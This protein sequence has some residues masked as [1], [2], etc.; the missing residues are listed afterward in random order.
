MKT[1]RLADY[2]AEGLLQDLEDARFFAR[3]L[4]PEDRLDFEGV[5]AVSSDFLDTLLA[6]QKPDSLEGRILNQ[7]GAVDEALVAWVDRQQPGRTTVAP[8]AKT[9]TRSP[10]AARRKTAPP[11]EF[12]RPEPEG[13][14]YTPTRLINRL[15]QQL[16]SYIES[17]YP[18]SDPVLVRARRRLLEE[19]QDGH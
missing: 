12:N 7:A 10:V 11:V 19:A 13:E 9:G 8:T 15:R 18:L 3:K 16:R 5:L 4:G 6:G 2:A 17:A 14:R 1:F